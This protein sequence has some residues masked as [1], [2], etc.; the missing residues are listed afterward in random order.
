TLTNPAD[1][2]FVNVRPNVNSGV[3]FYLNDASA[4]CGRKINRDA[5]SLP[6]AGQSGTLGRNALRGCGPCQSALP[7]HP[8][9]S[10]E[11]NGRVQFRAE[12]FNIFNH[13][14][15]G[16]IQTSLT[17]ANFGQPTNML[18]RQLG[19]LSPLYQIGGSRSIQFT[20]KLLF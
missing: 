3:P 8:R 12:A 19:G 5:F 2:S 16:A 14:N 1:G 17:A 13:P 6:A 11:G 20:L 4:L 7:I 9:F 18:N 15:F 10:F